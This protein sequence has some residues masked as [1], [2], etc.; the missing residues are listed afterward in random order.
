[1][2]EQLF[3]RKSELTFVVRPDGFK[4]T[5]RQRQR[6]K[7]VQFHATA[8]ASNAGHTATSS[9][10]KTKSSNQILVPENIFTRRVV[11]RRTD[12][13]SHAL[14]VRIAD[15]GGHIEIDVSRLNGRSL[16]RSIIEI[17]GLRKYLPEFDSLT[18]VAR[19]ESMEEIFHVWAVVEEAL[20]A[21]SRFFTLIDIYGHYANR[22]DTVRVSAEWNLPVSP[23]LLRMLNYFSKTDNCGQ[24][25]PVAKLVKAL[26]ST[27][28]QA[29]G[30]VED[31][32][33]IRFD[34]RT[35][36]THPII[37]SGMILCTYPFPLLS[38]RALV[39]SRARILRDQQEREEL[40]V[41]AG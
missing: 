9:L 24:I 29:I 19:I 26:R 7:S 37:K 16:P 30:L 23:T 12:L 27:E 33:A 21:R 20:V 38:P 15:A 4:S 35:S 17:N 14:E 8:K 3:E 10:K 41:K 1:M 6:A 18:L 39:E 31:L 5:F 25:I 36:A 2:R 22:G 32:R 13:P 11:R 40:M 34:T 28:K